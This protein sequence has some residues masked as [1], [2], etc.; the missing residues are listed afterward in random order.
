[1]AIQ[2]S[3]DELIKLRPGPSQYLPAFIFSVPTMAFSLWNGSQLGHDRTLFVGTDLALVVAMVLFTVWASLYTGVTLTRNE[4]VVTQFRTRHIPWSRVQ[5]VTP[6]KLNGS[7]WVTLWMEDGTRIR[8][9]TPQVPW[10]LPVRGRRSR[11]LTGR[12]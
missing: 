7:R 12:R 8:L 3:A 1:M 5:A 11:E 4:A 6:D 2:A 9:P 10:P